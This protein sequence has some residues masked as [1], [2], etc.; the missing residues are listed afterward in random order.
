MFSWFETEIL[1]LGDSEYSILLIFMV[2]L[3]IYLLYRSH[4]AFRRYRFMSG[5]ATSKIRSASQGYIELKG[6]GEFM[7]GDELISPFSGRRC[8]WYQCTV[9]QKQ[10]T[11][12]RVSWINIS[13][14][15]SD[16]L[17]HLTDDTGEC[18]ID[19][20][21]AHVVAE[22][23]RT[24]YGHGIEDRLRPAASSNAIAGIAI[25]EYRFSEKL[26][27]PACHIYALGFFRTLQ[28]TAS[29]ATVEAQVKD[30][31]R[32]W[33]LQP[34]RYLSQFDFDA[35]GKIAKQ[36][37]RAI[38]RKARQQVISKIQQQQSQNILERPQETA[39]PFILSAVDEEKLVYRKK[40]LSFLAGSV[41]FLLFVIIIN[42]VAVRSS[43]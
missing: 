27:R 3:S 2:G 8:L 11:S 1:Q 17:F 24:W 32:Q 37:W 9:E 23:N 7:H 16:N 14:E 36:E 10:K 15:I 34:H 35:N 38:H 13:N 30:L 5:T 19:P 20:E 42:L 28:N 12:K 31:L 26:I 18:V 43:Y 41:A 40:L 21:D 33:K 39:Q 22:L 6:I 4:A 29:V 25:G